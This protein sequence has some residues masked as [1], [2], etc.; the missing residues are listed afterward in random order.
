MVSRSISLFRTL[1]VDLILIEDLVRILQDGIDDADLPASIGDIAARSGAHEG[2]PEDDG[3]VLG[4]HAV[5]GGVLG[6][7]VQVQGQGAQGGVV[8]VG[9]PVDDGVQAVAAHDVVI[10]LGGL[11]EVG[12]VLAR[13]QRVRQVAQE[14]LQQAR[15]AVHVVEEVLR[16]AEVQDPRF[17]VC[18]RGQPRGA[19]GLRGK[20]LE[21]TLVLV[22]EG[23]RGG[24]GRGLEGEKG[25]GRPTGIKEGLQLL[26][27]RLGP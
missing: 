18:G 20:L 15:Y 6:D 11:D 17:R 14:L 16:V 5:D 10:V 2:R 1:L 21:V 9:Q 26:D 27:V 23:R 12:V 13:Q 4:V 22:V 24:R 25:G 8:G 7:A 19:P 3:E